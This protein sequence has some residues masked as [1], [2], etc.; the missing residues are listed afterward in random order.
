RR[1]TAVVPPLFVLAVRRHA[2]VRGAGLATFA[3]VILVAALFLR[4]R[5]EVREIVATKVPDGRPLE[6]VAV[7]L[8]GPGIEGR[9]GPARTGY[10]SGGGV[11]DSAGGSGLIE[12]GGGGATSA[13]RPERIHGLPSVAVAALAL[14]REQP[15]VALADGGLFVR[16]EREWRELRSGWG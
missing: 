14:W 4:V 8:P 3:G 10:R 6:R 11:V 9:G 12:V 13:P 7:R 1:S 5:H 16:S 2:W 15:V